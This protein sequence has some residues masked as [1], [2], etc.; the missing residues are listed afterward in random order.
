MGSQDNVADDEQLIE[1]LRAL[2]EAQRDLLLRQLEARG[3]DIDKSQ[4]DQHSHLANRKHNTSIRLPL[5]P[6]QLHVWLAQQKQPHSNAYHIAFRWDVMG[7]LNLQYIKQ[8]LNLISKRHQVLRLSFKFQEGQTWQVID[9]HI[10]IPIET[11]NCS[12]EEIG[13]CIESLVK[14]PFDLEHAPLIRVAAIK[15]NPQSGLENKNILVFIWHHLI[16]DGASRG[17]FI[18]ELSHIY[19]ELQSGHKSSLTH[20][21]F[22]YIDYLQSYER[23]LNSTEIKQQ[24]NYWK[25]K[26]SNSPSPL[27]PFRRSNVDESDFASEMLDID[28][29]AELYH[30]VHQLAREHKVTS[31]LILLTGFFMLLHRYGAGDDIAVGIPVAGR[32][33]AYSKTN[34]DF[35]RLLGFFVN[36]LVLRVNPD[37]PHLVSKWLD[38]LKITFSDAFEHQHLSLADTI[39]LVGQGDLFSV[40]FQYQNLA[41]ASQNAADLSERFPGLRIAQDFIELHQTKFDLTLHAIERDQNLQLLVEYR[42]AAFEH[43][44]IHDLSNNYV[45]LLKS[46]VEV[47]QSKT[48]STYVHSL[49]LLKEESLHELHGWSG[50]DASSFH[51]KKIKTSQSIVEQFETIAEKYPQSTAVAMQEVDEDIPYLS[52]QRLNQRANALGHQLIRRGIKKEELIAVCYPRSPELLVALLGVLKA[53]AAYLPVEPGLPDERIAFMLDDAQVDTIL[54]PK[55]FETRFTSLQTNNLTPTFLQVT[56]KEEIT[57]PSRYPQPSQLAYCIYT[58]GST[59]KP[60]GTL[61]NHAGLSHYM[62]WCLS[63][64]PLEEGKGALVNSSIGF[65]ATITGLFSPLLAARTVTF[66]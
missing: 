52:Y 25:E 47:S 60:K 66:L 21:T 19:G 61:L 2:S 38:A 3:I 18:H 10:E 54:L 22:E 28:F 58:S 59:G 53:G 4:F 29:P 55:E 62:S 23:W 7:D 13:P 65:D 56:S 27:L 35:N 16:A 20:P 33:L 44:V 11:I 8:A 30:Q 46:W 39:D 26:L 31:F 50:F 14:R 36:T 49:A 24:K 12:S 64:Y 40:M 15:I 9:D 1:R 45:N 63:R 42:T 34:Q 41:Y 37:S 57:N 5:T 6:S 48:E 43:D 32:S 17:I 51:N